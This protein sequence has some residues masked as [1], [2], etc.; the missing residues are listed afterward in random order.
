MLNEGLKTLGQDIVETDM[1]FGDYRPYGGVFQGSG[2]ESIDLP[3]TVKKLEYGTFMD[4]QSLK[5]IRLSHGLEYIGGLCFS[6][7]GI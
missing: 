1:C 6:N 4:C 2:L 7:S 5:N 3:S